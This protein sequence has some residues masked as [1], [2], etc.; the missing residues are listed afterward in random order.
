MLEVADGVGLVA[1]PVLL[2]VWPR[3]R[4]DRSSQPHPLPITT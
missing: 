3:R 2:V 1:V 4:I